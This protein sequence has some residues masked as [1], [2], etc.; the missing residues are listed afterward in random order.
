M[1][2]RQNIR[3]T[4]FTLGAVVVTGLVVHAQ[5]KS[6]NATGTWSWSQTFGQNQIDITLKLKQDGEKLTGTITGFQGQ[7]NEIKDGMVKDGKVTFKVVRE[8][9]GQTNTTNYTGTLSGDSLKGKSE[10]VS[11]RE[12]DAKRAAQ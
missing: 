10:T 3:W 2:T 11:T 9:N 8:F 12:F 1:W 7:E 6:G 5:D 4:I